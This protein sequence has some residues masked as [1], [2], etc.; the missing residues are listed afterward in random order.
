MRILNQTEE[1]KNIYSKSRILIYFI[2]ALFTV[3]LIRIGYLQ[4]I[5]G[6]E[7]FQKSRSNFILPEKIFPARG[8]IFTDDGKILATTVPAFKIS[9]IP[10]FFYD[11]DN[12]QEQVSRLGSILSLN[13]EQEMQIETNL[14]GC[15]GRCR[16]LPFSIKEEI[17]KDDILSLS[18]YLSTIPGIIISSSYKR[19]YPLGEKTAHIT[20]YVSRIN[21]YEIEEFQEYDAESFTGKTGIEKGYER[22]LHGTYGENFH[23][24]DYMGRKID[25]TKLM[26]S[27]LPPYKPSAKGFSVKTTILS[28]LQEE[29]MKAFGDSS[30][31]A[32]VMEIK[33][34]NILAMYSSPSF[35][36]N[37]LARNKIPTTLWMEYSESILHPLINKGIKST[38]YPGS[39]FKALPAMAGLYYKLVKPKSTFLC[40]GCLVFGSETKCCWNKW[41]HG[42]VSLRT[43]LKE[44]CD[45]FYYYLSEELGIQK[46]TEFAG[47]F[48]V[49]RETGIDIPGEERGILPTKEWFMQNHPGQSLNKGYIMNLAIGQG[50]LRMTPLQLAVMYAAIANNGII[51]K[52]KLGKYLIDGSGKTQ[53]VEDEVI[54]VLDVD[55]K[56]FS[57]IQEAL[58]AVVN[59]PGGTAYNFADHTIPEAAGKTG[60]SQIISN[61]QK[62]KI[63]FTEDEK[64]LL[65]EDDA[66]FVAMFPYKNPE[67]VAVAVLEHGGHGGSDAAP[68][69]YKL[70]K[71]YYQ[72]GGGTQ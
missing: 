27:Q 55:K 51:M 39:T 13:A 38:Y 30:G 14:M 43:S 2:C 24:I 11:K 59:E 68:I 66:L 4:I 60:T 19:I 32:I 52:P 21:K 22:E 6:E 67:I 15:K 37:L 53:A 44:S 28:Y 45:I 72:K 16:Y 48:N 49:G 29:A 57:Q 26:N 34:G 65:T 23:I 33:T 17:P 40:T 25:M 69:V 50:D 42:Y 70:L 41:G 36:P 1:V 62:K 8:D 56:I 10:F 47:L 9:V 46:L 63:D 20:G 18:G 31:A 7:L 71:A 64:Q 61:V 5:K 35:D 54:R 12:L 58:W 3:L